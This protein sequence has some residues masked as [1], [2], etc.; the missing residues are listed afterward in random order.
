[1]KTI[2]TLMSVFLLAQQLQA[3]QVSKSTNPFKRVKHQQVDSRLSKKATE[4]LPQTTQWFRWD[5]NLS[6]WGSLTD[7]SHTT[8]NANGTIQTLTQVTFWNQ[9][10]NTSKIN[11]SYN[12]SKQLISES[13]FSWNPNNNVWDSS[14]KTMYSYDSHGY[15]TE[16]LSYYLIGNTWQLSWGY[17]TTNTYDANGRLIG[18]MGQS[19]NEDSMAFIN[20]SKSTYAYDGS[21]K[22]AEVLF[23]QWNDSTV[24]FDTTSKIINIVWYKW[25]P[26]LD[27]AMPLSFE[28]QAWDGNSFELSG[29]FSNS[30]D[31]HGNTTEEKEEAWDGSVWSIDYW[32]TYQLTYNANAV[33]TQ[34]ITRNWDGDSLV[35]DR[36]EVYSDFFEFTG[37]R[38]ISKQSTSLHIYPNPFTENTTILI[39]NFNHSLETVLSVYDLLGRNVLV[40]P[41]QSNQTSLEKGNLQNGIYTYHL[42]EN[43]AVS[44]TGKFIIE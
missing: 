34:Q 29:K 36:K 2:I 32:N 1:M 35:N 40:Q 44:H 24:Q 9:S 7:S 18:D 23:L 43:G 4:S 28:L 26:N 22:I 30:Y 21:G 41:I 12:A 17:K 25:N 8:Y 14:G 38:A 27:D 15:Q 13:R 33:L 5:D 39:D 11:Y 3:A 37:I 16:N 10:S 6:D 42:T 31:S 20:E 19:W